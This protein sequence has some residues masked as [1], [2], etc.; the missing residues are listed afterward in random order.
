[1]TSGSSNHLTVDYCDIQ[2][3]EGGFVLNSNGTA[4]WG[5]SNLIENPF[6]AD[7]S[8]GDYGLKDCST[9]IGA[10]TAERAPEQDIEG[11]TRGTPPD[12]GAY[13]NSLD[14]PLPIPS[15]TKYVSVSGSDL[16][17]DGSESN[18]YA[19]IQKGI[20][21]VSNGDI[22]CVMDGIYIGEGNRDISFEGKEITVESQ[23][24]PQNCI[25][26]C[27]GSE[28]NPHIAFVFDKKESLDTI[29]EGFT[30]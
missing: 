27:Q 10:G 29:L 2:N 25:I 4:D 19:T 13:E 8:S 23:N 22:V 24:G 6:F 5:G 9:C 18:P 11:K 21:E 26:D 7:D 28:S 16:T 17:G 14:V 12:I 1:M 30:Q 20:N 15:E 3:G